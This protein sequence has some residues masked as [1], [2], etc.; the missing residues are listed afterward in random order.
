[1]ETTTVRVHRKI[2]Y[3]SLVDIYYIIVPIMYV[4]TPSLFVITKDSCVHFVSSNRLCEDWNDRNAHCLI[5][6]L[7]FH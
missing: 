7:I 1:M 3:I 5:F 4:S 2:R 6:F